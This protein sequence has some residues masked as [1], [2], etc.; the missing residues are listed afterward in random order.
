MFF[1]GDTFHFNFATEH[2]MSGS[3]VIEAM[4]ICRATLSNIISRG[5][6]SVDVIRFNLVRNYEMNDQA[7]AKENIS[8]LTI[9]HLQETAYEKLIDDIQTIEDSA[10]EV[11]K[12]RLTSE[13]QQAIDRLNAASRL[14]KSKI[15][16]KQMKRLPKAKMK[17]FDMSHDVSVLFGVG[18]PHRREISEYLPN[19]SADTQVPMEFLTTAS[20]IGL[21]GAARFSLPAPVQMIIPP[22]EES[23]WP[24]PEVHPQSVQD[25]SVF[26]QMAHFAPEPPRSSP[27]GFPGFM[28]R[29]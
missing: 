18:R 5:R 16:H 27:G 15:L 14:D 4:R 7:L 22:A 23:A 12:K 10:S 2:C 11:A 26:P 13:T 19:I 3:R 1:T 24:P 6:R 8:K 25:D 20:G 9:I 28:P 21:C 17:N 29:Y